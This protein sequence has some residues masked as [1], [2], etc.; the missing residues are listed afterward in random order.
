MVSFNS[1][2]TDHNNDY[3]IS[4]DKSHVSVQ[5]KIWSLFIVQL[6]PR[7]RFSLEE[8]RYVSRTNN[9]GLFFLRLHFITPRKPIYKDWYIY[10]MRIIFYFAKKVRERQKCFFKTSPI[11]EESKM[12]IF[13]LVMVTM[14][15]ITTTEEWN[16]VTSVLKQVIQM[17][18]MKKETR[19]T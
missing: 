1:P 9:S 16:D 12:L 15:M 13:L 3:R 17:L 14:M 11:F 18:A 7:R 19:R 4:S 8:I 10:L 5:K 6:T 2:Y